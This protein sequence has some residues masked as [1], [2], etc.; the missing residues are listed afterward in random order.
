MRLV[1]GHIQAFVEVTST[2][3]RHRDLTLEMARREIFDRYAGQVLGAYW[4]IGHPLFLMGL[5]VFVFAF[6]F[7]QK[8]GGTYDLP[9]DYTA[10]LLA[11]LIPWLS[12]Q[13]AMIK[14]CSAVSS[15]AALVK[16]TVF[17]IEALPAKGVVSSLV[18]QLVGSALLIVYVMF[19][20]GSLPWTYLLLPLLMS[21]QIGIMLGVAFF[22]SALG[23]FV[24][25]TKDVVQLL[26]TAGMYLLPIFYLPA[27]VPALFKPLLYANP[28]SH[29]I[30]CYQDILYFG[31]FEHPWSW[32]VTVLFSFF[33]LVLGYRAFRLMK[34]S[35]GNVL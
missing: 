22:L 31:R 3:A 14:S 33:G 30:W 6:V 25:D 18:T 15:S 28:F 27:W 8:I 5:Y 4:A 35:F 29:V 10:Y 24:K 23:V 13:E 17:P 19:T 12:I 21:L 16:Q 9:L 20:H 34:P 26:A 1:K 11:G 32:L 7:K 2:L